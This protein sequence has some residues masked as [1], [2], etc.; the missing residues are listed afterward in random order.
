MLVA[1]KVTK[2]WQINYKILSRILATPKIIAAVCNAENLQWCVWFG[3]LGTLEH[4]LLDCKH[5]VC[6]HQFLT[7]HNIFAGKKIGAC[8]WIFGSCSTFLN[9]IFWLCNFAVYKSHLQA[10]NNVLV[11]PFDQVGFEFERYSGLYPV[12][13]EFLW[14]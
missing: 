2:F 6:L 11:C 5:T 12:L 3:A 7:Q 9:P 8:H 4:I 14:N 1:C 13:K 10:C